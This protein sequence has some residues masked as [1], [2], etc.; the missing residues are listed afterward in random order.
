MEVCGFCILCGLLSKH[1][2]PWPPNTKWI[3][4]PPLHHAQSHRELSSKPRIQDLHSLFRLTLPSANYIPSPAEHIGTGSN[5]PS[6]DVQ[7]AA[8]TAVKC[9]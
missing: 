5:Q 7:Q 6:P 1:S 8:K 9:M 4:L 2:L 3:R